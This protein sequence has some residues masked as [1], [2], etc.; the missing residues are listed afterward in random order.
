MTHLEQHD[1]KEFLG[2]PQL[3]GVEML[4][5]GQSV[6]CGMYWKIRNQGKKRSRGS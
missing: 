1:A 3:K 2:T 4:V 5:E 6:I